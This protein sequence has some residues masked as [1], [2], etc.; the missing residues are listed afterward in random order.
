M[1]LKPCPRAIVGGVLIDGTGRP[2]A[3][4]SVVVLDGDRIVA[5]G[6][7]GE[8]AVPE[9]AE[10]IDAAGRTVLPGLID[11][12][13]HFLRMGVAMIRLI[14]LSGAESLAEAVE[15][16]GARVDETPVGEW[17]MGRGWDE[18]KWEEGR[19]VTKDDLDPISPDRPVMV[20]R[21]CGHLIT[22]NSRA[23]ELAGVTRETP[24][25]PGGRIDRGPGGEPMGVLRDA[26]HLVE[27]VIP[28]VTEEIALEGLRRACELA[29]S[30]GCTGVH[31]AGVDAF[32]VGIYQRAQER[33]L[34]KVRAYLMMAHPLF[35]AAAELGVRTGFGNEMLRLGSAKLLIDGSL[36][37][38][39]A[40]L[41]EAYADDPET[42]GLLMMPPEELTERVKA[43]HIHGLQAA[44]HAIGDRGI[45]HALNAVE[46]AL[47]EAPRRDHR[48][49]VE[50]CEVLTANQI[51]RLRELGVVAS[52]QPNFV[53]E[54]SGSEG[55][56]EARLGRRRLRRNNPYRLLLDEGV[57]VA[58]GSDCMPFNPLYGLWSAVNHPVRASRITL[59]EAV[60]CYTL[61]AAY[62]SFEEDLRG[63][64]E[65]GK[66]ADI[67]I[68][69]G[70]LT[71]LPSDEI[72]DVPVHMTIV[73]GKILYRRE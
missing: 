58:F 20:T 6:R 32:S 9:D 8:L 3:K 35:R 14:D 55:M 47:R 66:L 63:S 2:P 56:Y 17:V 4:D 42:K 10:V 34:L 23:L 11:A 24:D 46:E 33:G 29:L 1:P 48:H 5:V 18:S 15:L 59:E 54:W 40:A 31:D 73:G 61:D 16:V 71:E 37:A 21:V 70:D 30:L 50:H 45:E 22:L 64:V 69:D 49:R 27:K 44:V 38:R 62:A 19:Y 25:P 43:A 36:G 26:R 12:H 13:T 57:R 39:T 28:P 53:G 67:T 60:R 72:K 7:R 41:F 52:V 51:E 68:L 65:P